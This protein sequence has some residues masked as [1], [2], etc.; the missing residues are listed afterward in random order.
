MYSSCVEAVKCRNVLH[1]CVVIF[2]LVFCNQWLYVFNIEI[3]PWPKG[4]IDVALFITIY[5]E[6][7][8]NRSGYFL[9]VSWWFSSFSQ[10]F[11]NDVIKVCK[12]NLGR[13]YA[14]ATGIPCLSKPSS[15]CST[16]RVGETNETKSHSV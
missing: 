11:Y 14:Q 6:F 5:E 1:H 13:D 12:W 9:N 16:K 7:Q 2:S 4:D 10:I 15:T 3:R 8:W